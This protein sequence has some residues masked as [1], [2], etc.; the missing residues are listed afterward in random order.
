MLGPESSPPC[1]DTGRSERQEDLEATGSI[2]SAVECH[3]SLGNLA[4]ARNGRRL[5]SVSVLSERSWVAWSA[6]DG[7]HLHV[8][9]T[10]T[11]RAPKCQVPF[12]C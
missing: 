7:H 3:I 12:M 5:G 8:P 1:S 4:Q 11:F 2:V 10:C 9:I 6:R